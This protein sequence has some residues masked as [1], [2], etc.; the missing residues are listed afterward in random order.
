MQ[1]PKTLERK[2]IVPSKAID[3]LDRILGD[4]G[5]VSIFFGDNQVLFKT[6]AIKLVS[7]LIEGEFPPYERVIPEEAK[8]KVT[9]PREGFLSAIKRVALFT[10]A[11][12]MSVRVDLS[13]DKVV[14]SKSTPY[15]GDARVETEAEYKGKDLSVGFNPGHIINLL[16]NVDLEKVAFEIVDPEKPCAVRIG[17]EYV[18]VVSPMRLA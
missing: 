4:E 15:L 11:D 2:I 16:K 10:S 6:S 3:E 13:R 14:V 12:S 17:N 7:R 1:L 8:E 18:Y 5:E 9:V